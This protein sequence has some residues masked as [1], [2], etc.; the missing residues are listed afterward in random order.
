MAE[1]IETTGIISIGNALGQIILRG[2]RVG[3]FYNL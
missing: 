1:L 3:F 2:L